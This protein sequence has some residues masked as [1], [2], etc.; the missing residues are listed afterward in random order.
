MCVGEGPRKRK[1]T[2]AREEAKRGTRGF[3]PLKPEGEPHVTKSA[4]LDADVESH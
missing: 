4:C 3:F 2:G 1:V